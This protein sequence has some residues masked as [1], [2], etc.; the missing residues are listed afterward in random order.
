[1]G[2]KVCGLYSGEGKKFLSPPNSAQRLRSPPTHLVNFYR[3]SFLGVKRSERE[4]E[5]S[6]ASSAKIRNVCSSTSIPHACLHGL[7]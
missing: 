7:E 5:R 6:L 3:R 1:M 2:W 4:V